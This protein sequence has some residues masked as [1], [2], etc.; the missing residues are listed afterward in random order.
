MK[1][2]LF[3]HP[4]GQSFSF[5][6]GLFNYITGHTRRGFNRSIHLNCGLLYYFSTFLGGG[7][8][9]AV[10][11][12]AQKEN[13]NLDMS[14]HAYLAMV[15]FLLFG[16]GGATGF[17]LMRH[18]EKNKHILKYHKAVNGLS[19]VLVLILAVSGY[20]ELSML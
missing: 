20:F 9:Y 10:A 13:F 19:L 11:R 3:I 12:W 7:I 14:M 5:L 15:I 4:L 18:R 17:F 2:V 16:I 1:E 6:F 8:G